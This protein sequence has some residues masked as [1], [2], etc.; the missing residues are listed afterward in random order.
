VRPPRSRVRSRLV[1]AAWILGAIV[2]LLLL[3]AW[4]APKLLRPTIE[5]AAADALGA[6]VSIGSIGG[7]P[8]LAITLYDV[9]VSG[10][11]GSLVRSLDA[12][13]VRVRLRPLRLAL[14]RPGGIASVRAAVREA[15]IDATARREPA[16]DELDLSPY[17]EMG[18]GL[19]AGTLRILAPGASVVLRGIDLD[20]TGGRGRVALDSIAI[21]TESDD[22]EVAAYPVGSFGADIVV[23]SDRVELRDLV[24][25]GNRSAGDHL[26]FEL[27]GDGAPA[28]R[29]RARL[30]LLDGR[31]TA[32]GSLEEDRYTTGFEAAGLSVGPVAELLDVDGGATGTVSASA[33]VQGSI[34][35]LTSAQ[36]TASIELSAVAVANGPAVSLEARAQV[37]GRMA[38][39]DEFE[40]VLD[41]GVAPVTLSGSGS[42]DFGGGRP[43]AVADLASERF[44]AGG[45]SL[46]SPS[47]HVEAEFGPGA[48]IDGEAGVAFREVT[49]ERIRLT[50]ASLRIAVEG[51]P[52]RLEVEVSGGGA[53]FEVEARGLVR[54]VDG[55]VELAVALL[56]GRAGDASFRARSPFD[57]SVGT[58]GKLAVRGAEFAVLEGVARIDGSASADTLDLDFELSNI[59]LASVLSIVELE[60]D[61]GGR[62][63]GRL[64]LTGPAAAPVVDG[65]ICVQGG[66]A[67]FEG[68]PEV[69]EL[70]GCVRV[71]QDFLRIEELRARAAGGSFEARGTTRL[72]PDRRPEELDLVVDFTGNELAWIG[73]VVDTDVAGIATGNLRMQG[74]ASRPT[75]DL[76]LAVS[77]GSIEDAAGLS[78]NVSARLE[79]GFLQIEALRCATAETVLEA[80]GVVPLTVGIDPP[81]IDVREEGI[82]GE[83]S[84]VC[85]DLEHLARNVD[86]LARAGQIPGLTGFAP[87]EVGGTARVQAHVRGTPSR[88]YLAGEGSLRGGVLR[89]GGPVPIDIDS[90]RAD[91][92]FRRDVIRLDRMAARVPARTE[93][94]AAGSLEGR[95]ILALVPRNVRGTEIDVTLDVANLPLDRIE[96]WV[97]ASVG[98]R[99]SGRVRL[100]HSPVD[101]TLDMTLE[102]RDLSFEGEGGFAGSIDA[103][104]TGRR[105]AL[106]RLELS[107]EGTSLVASGEA[108]LDTRDPESWL[109]RLEVVSQDAPWLSLRVPGLREVRLTAALER[110]RVEITALEASHG[111]TGRIR[112]QE[113]TS[114]TLDLGPDFRPGRIDLQAHV[115]ALRLEDLRLPID[116]PPQGTVGGSIEVIGTVS[117]PTVNVDLLARDVRYG[118]V[119]VEELHTLFTLDPTGLDGELRAALAPR[120]GRREE[121]GLERRT[122]A[123]QGRLGIE[124][125]LDPP[126]FDVPD[127]TELALSLS[128]A[129]IAI[130]ALIPYPDPVRSIH[131]PA[132]VDIDVAGTL[133][134]PRIDGKVVLDGVFVKFRDELFATIED[135]RGSLYF[136]G[137][138]V[139]TPGLAMMFGREIAVARGRAALVK[140]ALDE[141]ELSFGGKRLLL[142]AAPDFRMR[143]DVDLALSGTG[144]GS[145]LSGEVVID[146]SRYLRDLKRGGFS[147][148]GALGRHRALRLPIPELEGPMARS[149]VL[150]VAVRADPD[151]RFLVDTNV[152]QAELEPDL[153]LGG[154]AADPIL[155]GTVQLEEGTV[156]TP[157]AALAMDSGQVQ[158]F[159]RD[160]WRPYVNVTS[161][162]RI[163]SY[164]VLVRARGPVDDIDLQFSSAPPLPPED[165]ASLLATGVVRSRLAGEGAARA[166][167]SQGLRYL[168]RR[169]FPRRRGEEPS[170][171]SRLSRRVTVETLP[172]QTPAS[173]NT[174]VRGQIELMPRWYL[175]GELDEFGDYNFDVLYRIE[176]G[177]ASPDLE[178]RGGR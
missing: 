67:R 64:T 164:D 89:M 70:E 133:G 59:D 134:F 35:N 173:A 7:H 30:G 32:R 31:V 155:T 5:R 36:G 39:V 92:I 58:G 116:L 52:R 46:V 98:G 15:V 85:T 169:L 50:G 161:T 48:R 3:A 166:A 61:L 125:S 27:P 94:A 16:G 148:S 136:E 23:A 109:G 57:L 175:R 40:G 152:V 29:F 63:G 112:L 78:A 170:L 121:T 158:F 54:R 172:A 37:L 68:I 143:A 107:R 19:R 62:L 97:D 127:D 60:G 110:G 99:A 24:L 118:E 26:V 139:R 43:R 115:V 86:Q 72:G 53:E 111:K 44:T 51:R 73:D 96:S 163:S 101:P 178:E 81:R 150:D 167:G 114:G 49:G 105:V 47:L 123:G 129:A 34:D 10:E 55:A 106:E 100:R 41:D 146:D 95:G 108:P 102:L 13:S 87:D 82:A 1:R 56:R 8:L 9:V 151:R 130:G 33:L 154:T 104:L 69:T 93:G 165:V 137:T 176:F 12:E 138:S 75:V 141:V 142:L 17:L 84:L 159:E 45:V 74:E 14:G 135:I 124:W 4:V 145:R 90:V 147:A 174:I 66:S 128:G 79:R 113:G 28:Y 80:S 117:S 21:K 88:P 120:V 18:W 6:D 20:E 65:E 153:R 149:V 140:G 160:P 91:A 38:R 131:G 77:E 132:T 2:T 22:G 144:E 103:S 156:Y 25:D 168:T 177:G 162:T 42:L 126:R 171:I 157:T 11:E 83:L 76:V 71:E 119:A 122:L